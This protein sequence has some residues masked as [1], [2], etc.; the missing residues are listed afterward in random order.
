MSD[1]LDS[2]QGCLSAIKAERNASL[3]EKVTIAEPLSFKY[4]EELSFDDHIIYSISLEELKIHFDDEAFLN[5][6]KGSQMCKIVFLN[7]NLQL[8]ADI[9]KDSEKFL[10][11]LGYEMGD[12][13]SNVDLYPSPNLIYEDIVKSTLKW[14]GESDETMCLDLQRLEQNF[15][16]IKEDLKL[17]E[18]DNSVLNIESL[19]D[20]Q[21]FLNYIWGPPGTGK[22]YNTAKLL[23]ELLDEGKN[24]LV[25]SISNQAVDNILLEFLKHD[26]SITKK[27]VRFGNLLSKN[28]GKLKDY[29]GEGAF[30][31][32]QLSKLVFKRDALKDNLK[33]YKTNE[34][35]QEAIEE[36]QTLNKE[37]KDLVK[38]LIVDEKRSLF[39][40]ITQAFV[41]DLFSQV[42]FDYLIIEEASMVSE[43][44]FRNLLHLV[45]E[46]VI[47]VGDPKQLPPVV[48]TQDGEYKKVL[49]KTPFDIF[50]LRRANKIQSN[51]I[52]LNK[53]NRMPS[54]ITEAL[55]DE[56]MMVSFME[57]YLLLVIILI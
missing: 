57:M 55:S 21:Y 15:K 51:C 48:L 56:F 53:S 37:I 41:S 2:M 8:F 5:D 38:K 14:I 29:S 30:E 1:F 13:F 39:T 20:N 45:S 12:E 19:K 26:T 54:E 18:T 24:C 25:L 9:S 36:I 31:N 33:V 22:T 17:A 35:R 40:T 11:H 43:V 28:Y 4:D 44:V 34:K 32:I 16:R 10:L 27:P 49:N 42:H 52:F 46:K 6:L 47:C 3:S 7:N 50:G 23:N